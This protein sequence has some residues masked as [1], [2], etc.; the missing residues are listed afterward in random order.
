MF[1]NIRNRRN[2][3]RSRRDIWQ[4]T[5][6]LGTRSNIKSEW[7]TCLLEDVAAPAYAQLL[8]EAAKQLGPTPEFS[9]LWPVGALRDPW[10]R[11]AGKLYEVVVDLP[12]LPTK[13]GEKLV[14]SHT[15]A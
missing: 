11:M 14:Q 6:H 10:S 9:R 8:A 12:V 2:F 1:D 7:N 15:T 13:A 3:L 5:D 4:G